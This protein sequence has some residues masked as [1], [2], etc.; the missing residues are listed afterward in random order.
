MYIGQFVMCG[1]VGYSPWFPRGADKGTF[2]C[3]LIAKS[4]SGTLDIDVEH[5]NPTDSDGSASACATSEA[6]AR[7]SSLQ[8]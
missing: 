1:V 7:P 3:E 2:L 8:I 4:T 6:G 5:K